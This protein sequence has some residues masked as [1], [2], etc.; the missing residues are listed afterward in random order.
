[1]TLYQFRYNFATSNLDLHINL[2]YIPIEIIIIFHHLFV[3]EM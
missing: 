3:E 2:L 1:M